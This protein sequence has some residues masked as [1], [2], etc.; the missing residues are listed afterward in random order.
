MRAQELDKLRKAALQRGHYLDQFVSGTR[1]IILALGAAGIPIVRLE[2]AKPN[3]EA[4]LSGLLFVYI[5]LGVAL[6]VSMTLHVVRQDIVPSPE[7]PRKETNIRAYCLDNV[8]RW[9]RY[10]NWLLTS[11]WMLISI[12]LPLTMESWKDN[13]AT[14]SAIQWVLLALAGAVVAAQ[15]GYG[16]AHVVGP[17]AQEQRRCLLSGAVIDLGGYRPRLFKGFFRAKWSLCWQH[18]KCGYRQLQ[19]N[20]GVLPT[21]Q[22]NSC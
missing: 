15:L 4:V 22:K 7:T 17:R 19:Q 11:I 1:T 6:V 14:L 10:R 12:V 20:S 8:I 21:A 18:I 3:N 5:V 13:S 16:I 2:R 9:N